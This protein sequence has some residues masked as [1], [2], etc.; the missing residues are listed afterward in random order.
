MAP[1]TLSNAQSADVLSDL[2]VVLGS[3]VGVVLLFALVV[4]VLQ[5]F[6]FICRP[7]EV[8]V[9]SGRKHTLADGTV[10]GYKILAGGR[11][12]RIPFLESVSQLDM[13]LYPVEVHVANAYSKGGIPLSVHA[14]ANVKIASGDIEVRNAAERFLGASNEAIAAAAKQT[15]EGVLREVIAQL[16]PEE[17]NEDRL[18]FAETL[19]E[20]AR[21][22]LDK[23]GLDLDVLKVQN[24]TDEQQYLANLGRGRIAT[25]LRDAANAENAANQEVAEAQ[26]TARQSAGMAVKRAETIVLQSR[27][28]A[29]GELAKL[30]STAKQIENEAEI[31]SQTERALAEQEL[32]GLRAELEKLRLHCDV[33]LPA[34]A[35]RKAKVLRARGEAAP[36]IENGKAVA[37]SLRVVAEEWARAGDIGRDLFMLQRLREIIVAAAL[38]VARTEVSEVEVVAGDDAEA[39]AA[40]VAAHPAAVARVLEETGRALGFDINGLIGGLGRAE[41]RPS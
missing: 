18:K 15:L 8:L 7:N 34:A 2:L 12:F 41:G 37:E 25:M 11:G 38:R 32:Q 3:A 33:V 30:E 36:T 26:A 40:V 19:V 1:D 24:V 31:A 17:V 28:G 10:S 6:L 23:L 27:N 5:R 4:V 21:D 35:A 20:N 39:Y 22:D 13:R 29:R 16:T 14:I 9:F